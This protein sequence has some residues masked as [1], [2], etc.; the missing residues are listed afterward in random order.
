MGNKT[1]EGQHRK[2]PTLTSFVCSAGHLLLRCDDRICSTGLEVIVRC[3]LIL[4]NNK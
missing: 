2:V 4:K 1:R 3:V